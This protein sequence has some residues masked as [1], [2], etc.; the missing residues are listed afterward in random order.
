MG[1]DRGLVG[2]VSHRADLIRADALDEPVAGRGVHDQGGQA[3]MA[4][5]HLRAPDR[6]PGLGLDAAAHLGGQ[7]GPGNA[8]V[9]RS[10]SSLRVVAVAAGRA[11]G[12][13]GRSLLGAERGEAGGMVGVR[14]VAVRGAAVA[15]QVARLVESQIWYRRVCWMV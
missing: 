15:V 2:L 5:G 1:I 13:G 10:S 12:R 4:C 8:R 9:H 11:A 6:R 14:C 7:L 3:V